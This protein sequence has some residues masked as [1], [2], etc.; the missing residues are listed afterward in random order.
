M[1]EEKASTHATIVLSRTS[2][3]DVGIREIYVSIDGRDAGVL[4]PGT[5][6]TTQVQP[7]HHVIKAHN[8]LFWRTRECDL[9]AGE[10]AEF[11]G[12]NKAGGGAM[13][14]SILMAVLGVGALNLQF[15]RIVAP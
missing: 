3:D 11:L 9:A 7:G 8:T 5:T 6:I 12:V 15:E 2:P 1:A 4:R 14:L 10:T 13:G